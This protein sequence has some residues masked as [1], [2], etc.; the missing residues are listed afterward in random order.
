VIAA[1]PGS[2][3][4]LCC[5]TTLCTGHGRIVVTAVLR[6]DPLSPATAIAFPVQQCGGSCCIGDQ[7]V[8]PFA[9]DGGVNGFVLALAAGDADATW[10]LAKR[11]GIDAD[12][13]IIQSARHVLPS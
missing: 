10:G 6:N 11:V 2:F 7:D 9:S 8:D 1:T 3:R 13:S 4:R 12:H 5:E